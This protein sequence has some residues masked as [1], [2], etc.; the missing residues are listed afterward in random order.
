M[1]ARDSVTVV[2]RRTVENKTRV[3]HCRRVVMYN[4][5]RVNSQ[6][7]LLELSCVSVYLNIAIAKR[8]CPIYITYRCGDFRAIY[9]VCSSTTS[10]AQAK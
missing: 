3:G 1:S 6:R 5:R 7:D 8:F 4:E 10:A 9:P 2:G